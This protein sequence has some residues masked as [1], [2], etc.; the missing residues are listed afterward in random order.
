M[1]LPAN[2]C[3]ISRKP[4]PDHAVICCTS[5][6]ITPSPAC[7]IFIYNITVCFVLFL[8]YLIALLL[9]LC[10]SRISF[11]F[12]TFHPD[13]TKYWNLEHRNISNENLTNYEQKLSYVLK[14]ASGYICG[15]RG[16]AY[17]DTCWY[18]KSYTLFV[19]NTWI[20]FIVRLRRFCTD[21]QKVIIRLSHRAFC[22]SLSNSGKHFWGKMIILCFKSI[23]WLYKIN[24]NVR[25]RK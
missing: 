22:R 13:L 19:R 2:C 12:Y 1:Q 8:T 20:K 5:C 4:A 18:R 15:Q 9:E 7:F 11:T 21:E 16:I 24:Q 14:A 23:M 25:C 3:G 10:N 17:F 6:H